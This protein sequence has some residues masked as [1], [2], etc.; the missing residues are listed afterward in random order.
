MAKAFK[1]EKNKA[2]QHLP[3]YASG[4]DSILVVSPG[5]LVRRVYDWNA[6]QGV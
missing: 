4:S 3:D 6:A 5:A 2:I 1:A